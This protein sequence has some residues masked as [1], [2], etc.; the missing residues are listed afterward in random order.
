MEQKE[1]MNND[2]VAAAPAAPKKA[3]KP[4]MQDEADELFELQIL[5]FEPILYL[6]DRELLHN[7]QIRVVHQFQIESLRGAT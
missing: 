3:K 7:Q 1:I 2:S 6:L 5:L 4:T